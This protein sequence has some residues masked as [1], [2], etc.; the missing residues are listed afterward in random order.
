[1]LGTL[2]APERGQEVRPLIKHLV[3]VECGRAYQPRKGLYTCP[4]CGETGILDVI[5]DYEAIQPWIT[6]KTLA[7]NHDYSHWR[8]LPLLP[9]ASSETVQPLHVG[10]TPLLRNRRLEE[11]VG[12]G[13]LY[14]K[15]DG[16]NPTGSLKDRASS[17]GVAKALEEG[18]RTI[19]C[20]STGNAASSLAGFAASAGLK[21][22]IFVPAAAPE[23]KV[24]QLLIFGATVLLVQ[25]SYDE[26]YDLSAEAIRTY[27]WYNRNCAVNPYLV[28]GKK[29]VGFEIAE[30]LEWHVPDWVVMS[31]G[32]GCSIAGAGKA[33]DE[34]FR[35]GLISRVPRLLG[36][37]A[38]GAAPITEAF[39]NNAT[40]FRPMK[41]ETL[42]DSISVGVPRNFTKA[43]RQVRSSGGTMINVTDHE[44]LEAMRLMAGLT[45][46]FS[47]PAGS[48]AMAGLRA[49]RSAG[50]I[51]PHDSVV[52]VA[53]GNGL[54]DIQAALRTV[55]APHRI[56]PTLSDLT[57]CLGATLA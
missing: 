48:A 39:Y 23:A 16:R 5:Y 9:L 40:T 55:P 29:T 18:E 30:Q 47:E 25:G 42:A 24:T 1:M 45:G 12:V 6:R 49:A 26:A 27:G 57:E 3:C 7:A 38:T 2:L 4:A 15:D 44:I 54:K 17:V 52:V 21:A 33:F 13:R 46:V 53:S 34:L 50:V 11:A 28:E 19:A 14:I 56:R 22:F 32:D 8:Y 20:A 37:Q 41:P 51:G 36:V 31:V 43:I 10:W 35:L